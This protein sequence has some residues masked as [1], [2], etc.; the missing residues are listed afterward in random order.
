VV[1]RVAASPYLANVER[2]AIN[3]IGS[4]PLAIR[5]L[6]SRPTWTNLRSLRFTGRLSPDNVRDLAGACTLTGL[7]ELVLGLGNP[8]LFG[9]PVVEAAGTIVRA[10]LRV[11]AFPAEAAPQWI[12]YG[13][14][15]EA[16]TAAQWLRQ[17]RVLRITTGSWG[18]FRGMLGGNAPNDVIPD[19]AVL[20]L[21]SALDRDKLERLALP[22]SIV[23]GAVRE[24]LTRRLGTK[25]EFA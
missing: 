10:M 6:V 15:F 21:A 20:A 5:A 1:P 4:D 22:P 24:E 8:G 18:G 2:L 3:P 9:N 16:L 23:S 17:L 12:E 11:V 25:V 7:D 13:P 19:A 14:A